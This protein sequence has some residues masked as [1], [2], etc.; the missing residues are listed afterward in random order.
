MGDGGGQGG[1]RPQQS[2]QTTNTNLVK[3][4]QCAAAAPALGEEGVDLIPSP[5]HSHP[6]NSKRLTAGSDAANQ[7]KGRLRQ[8][9]PAGRLECNQ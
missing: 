2:A 7:P 1:G 6:Y 4:N 8:N 5:S 9:R 3:A